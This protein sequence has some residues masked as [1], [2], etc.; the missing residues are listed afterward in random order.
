MTETCRVC[1]ANVRSF[2][3]ATILGRYDIEYFLCDDCG[4]IQTESPY[5]L[6]EAYQ[7]VI[8]ATDV[9]LVQRNFEMTKITTRVM[10]YLFPRAQNGV[11]Y[12]GGYGMFTR[13]MRDRG[14]NFF[15]FDP[16]ANNLFAKGFEAS[17]GMHYDFLTAF[18]VWE[19][20]PDPRRDLEWMDRA[21][22][23]WLVSTLLLPD[24]PPRPNQWWYYVLEG[25]QHISL[26]SKRSMQI[27]AERYG[28]HVITTNR[29]VHLFTRDRV[30]ARLA[31]L[32]LK[33]KMGILFDLFNR[34]RSLRD[35]DYEAIRCSLAPNQDS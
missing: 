17:E 32:L 6:D 3:N 1:N 8:V 11:D 28:R 21:A 14:H 10:R 25:G 29:G 5:W 26:W 9:G 34:R 22:D 23:H 35:A 13:L 24:P 19:H 33:G 31:S 27:V 7:S 30:N 4:F 12:G 16:K 20:L 2:A 18:E 15:H